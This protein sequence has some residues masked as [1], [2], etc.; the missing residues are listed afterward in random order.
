MQDLFRGPRASA[1]ASN[2]DA[3]EPFNFDGFPATPPTFAA[4]PPSCSTTSTLLRN[5]E[6]SSFSWIRNNN[7]RAGPHD[8][9]RNESV[10]SG[11]NWPVGGEPFVGGVQLHEIDQKQRLMLQPYRSRDQQIFR[12]KGAVGSAGTASPS[13]GRISSSAGYGVGAVH[14]RREEGELCPNSYKGSSMFESYESNDNATPSFG[15][16]SGISGSTSNHRSACILDNTTEASRADPALVDN[17]GVDHASSQSLIA[18]YR[19]DNTSSLHIRHNQSNSMSRPCRNNCSPAPTVT[20]KRATIPPPR[21]DRNSLVSTPPPSAISKSGGVVN[22]LVS[23]FSNKHQQ[24]NQQRS[25]PKS[26]PGA[27]NTNNNLEHLKHKMNIGVHFHV[28][29][30]KQLSTN[31]G[32]YSS[33]IQKAVP[34]QL[35]NHSNPLLSPLA[36]SP[37][38]S[39]AQ[40]SVTGH[41][42]DSSSYN[43]TGW[44]GTVDKRGRTYAMER[45]YS[46]SEDN[47]ASSSIQ[48]R[49]TNLS[50]STLQERYPVQKYCDTTTEQQQREFSF[51]KGS[52]VSTGAAAAEL[53]DWIKEDATTHDSFPYGG[54]Y[55]TQQGGEGGR[56]E[57]GVD[58]SSSGLGGNTK[59][60]VD[61]DEA[62][63][64]RLDGENPHH[65][66]WRERGLESMANISEVKTAADIQ[67]EAALGLKADWN[68]RRQTSVN[69][70]FSQGSV[71]GGGG[72]CSSSYP[73]CSL[74]GSTL[75]NEEAKL[76]GIDL[77][78]SQKRVRASGRMLPR[79]ART[80]YNKEIEFS[81]E[82]DFD[83]PDPY[84]NS[85]LPRRHAAEILKPLSEE[86]LQWKDRQAALPRYGSATMLRGYRGFIDKT[87]DVPNLIDDLESEV[88]TSLGTGIDSAVMARRRLGLALPTT[89]RSGNGRSLISSSHVGSGSDIFEGIQEEPLGPA[90]FGPMETDILNVCSEDNLQQSRC[91]PQNNELLKQK[92][93]PLLHPQS[94]TG[95]ECEDTPSSDKVIPSTGGSQRPLAPNAISRSHQSHYSEGFA[96]HLRMHNKECFFKHSMPRF[97]NY[98]GDNLPCPHQYTTSTTEGRSPQSDRITISRQPH[99]LDQGRGTKKDFPDPSLDVSTITHDSTSGFSHHLDGFDEEEKNQ[100]FKS[101]PDLSIYCIHPEVVRKMVRTFRKICTNQ[102]EISTSGD[103]LYDFESLVDTKKAFALFE[104]RSR[105][106]ETDIDRGLER[107]GGTNVVD[108]IVLTAYSQ[109][110][111]RVRD[112]VIVSK[113]WRDGATPRDVVTAHLLTRR[114]VKAHFVRRPIRRQH[115]PDKHVYNQGP[116]FWLEE[117]RHLDDTDFQM[118]RCQSLGAGTMK[119]FEMFTI[120][121]CQ[122]ILLKMTSDNCT[123]LR[124]E[125]R[126]A[127]VRQIEVEELMQEEIN[128]DADENIVAEAEELYRDA[129]VEVKTL[130]IKL[131]LADKA[132]ALARKKMEQL[133]ETIEELLVQIENGDESED[134]SSTHSSNSSHC[135]R[136]SRDR[137]K[138]I[139]RAKR[140]EL[141]AE[142]AVREAILAKEE[143]EKIRADKQFE[144][145]QLK[146]KLADME[147]K[148][149]L[150][151]S[152]HRRL[153]NRSYLEV[154]SFLESS[155]EKDNEEEVARKER[156]KQKF[157]KRNKHPKEGDMLNFY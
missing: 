104:M 64:R 109:A 81:E 116:Q 147:T 15:H 54:D 8:A 10:V 157:H 140:A 49:I 56:K 7:A 150:V 112:A 67:L 39:N 119:G 77:S 17:I 91:M 92:P 156:L 28:S 121:D 143:T 52:A 139:V 149:Q 87:K 108:D 153:T 69:H 44:P 126:L 111:A 148:S 86:A 71:A 37:S 34:T 89:P 40:S 120:G 21:S 14:G 70:T 79:P 58:T 5:V 135:I 152:E 110:A 83:A 55:M 98:N 45:S 6:A 101:L 23:L 32:T 33:R 146:D 50:S 35:S 73:S 85:H 61:L 103:T 80:I 95:F 60:P 22:K 65:N 128:L 130:S 113:A 47:S 62:Y 145:D 29:P 74:S 24:S 36:L 99:H 68:R 20:Q 72:S 134:N 93:V 114:S 107:R 118:M 125:L 75:L 105:I 27:T 155:I 12:R 26:K 151:A 138:L 106:M 18:N 31:R 117:I 137:T 141:S 11:V 94:F 3:Y 154:K 136:E 100:E 132:F 59:G 53:K 41:S 25:S 4:S 142:V 51:D 90:V 127:M 46:E 122:S 57:S 13:S 96:Q 102:I 43:P 115:H 16:N 1:S 84:N 97:A 78:G 131:V 19:M 66:R 88:S 129:T 63:Q 38:R 76:Q 9:I 42:A 133:V 30:A 48:W 123:Q 124:R 2:G 82:V 144:I